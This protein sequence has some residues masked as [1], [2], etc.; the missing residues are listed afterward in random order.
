MKNLKI[1]SLVVLL[2][3]LVFGSC[4]KVEEALDVTFDATY[5]TDLNV[6]VPAVARNVS[7]SASSTIDPASDPDVSKYWD[8]I[9][10][11]EVQEVTG[12]ITSI[13]KEV[14]LVSADLTIAND[15]RTAKW[16]FNNV[17]LTVGTKLT[18]DNSGGQWNTVDQILQDK[19]VFTVR[20]N[21]EVSEGGVQFT[22][23]VTIKTKVTANPL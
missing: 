8:K 19:K 6:D 15:S 9:K 23:L 10:K 22:I 7:F 11:F 3:G 2:I 13:S 21:G 12:V 16:T 17:P 20:I 1:L 18:L 5:D 14:T 4:K